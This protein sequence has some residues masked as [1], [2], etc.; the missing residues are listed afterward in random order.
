[1]NVIGEVRGSCGLEMAMRNEPAG[2][3]ISVS[4]PSDF[5]TAVAFLR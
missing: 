4:Q 3:G 2:G 5:S 1:M